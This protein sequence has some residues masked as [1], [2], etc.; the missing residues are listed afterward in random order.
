MGSC[1]VQDVNGPVTNPLDPVSS[2]FLLLM[3][4][5]AERELARIAREA[6]DTALAERCDPLGRVLDALQTQRGV[7]TLDRVADLLGVSR[8]TVTEVYVA[9]LGLPVH[10]TGRTSP[11]LFLL[12]E[13]VAWVRSL[14]G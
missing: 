11:P 5:S 4:D 2:H 6:L 1:G 7:L 12:D 13:V 14:S 8:R 3:Q 9:K 10:R